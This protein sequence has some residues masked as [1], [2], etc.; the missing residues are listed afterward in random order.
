MQRRFKGAPMT[1]KTTRRVLLPCRGIRP[2][3]AEQIIG[4]CILSVMCSSFVIAALMYAA[5]KERDARMRD[6]VSTSIAAAVGVILAFLVALK[7]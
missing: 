2:L 1:R 6:T 5:Q 7:R 4:L 3:S